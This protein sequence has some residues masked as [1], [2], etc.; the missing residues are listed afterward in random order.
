MII[1]EMASLMP[2]LPRG[3]TQVPHQSADQCPRMFVYRTTDRRYRRL[4]TVELKGRA[5]ATSAR[6]NGVINDAH[7]TE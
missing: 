5:K 4:C 2:I 3:D 6:V 7:Y 1:D